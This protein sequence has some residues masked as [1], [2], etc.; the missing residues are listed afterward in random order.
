MP[1]NGHGVL[2]ATDNQSIMVFFK[3]CIALVV[4]TKTVINDELQAKC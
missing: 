3:V 4:M 2:K 1:A